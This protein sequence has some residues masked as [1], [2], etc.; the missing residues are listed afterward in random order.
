MHAVS[1]NQI[2]D[3]LPFSDNGNYLIKCQNER[4]II[5]CLIA[6]LKYLLKIP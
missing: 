5:I 6:G 2:A 1:T 4:Y 3:I